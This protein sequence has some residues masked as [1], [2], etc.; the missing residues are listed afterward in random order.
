[1]K[2]PGNIMKAVTRGIGD[3]SP[4]CRQAVRLQSAA[5]DRKLSFRERLGLRIHLLLCKWCRRYGKQIRFLQTATR[6]HAGE[7]QVLP[8]RT[9]S[10]EARE[11][12]KQRLQ[13]EKK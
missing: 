9:L 7:E 4:S 11:R 8:Q 6:E 2:W 1:M 10:P 3:L 5:L 13:S 12:I